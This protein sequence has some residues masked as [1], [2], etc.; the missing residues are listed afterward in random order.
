MPKQTESISTKQFLKELNGKVK[1]LG[2]INRAA[3]T[4]DVSATF[5]RLVLAGS[6]TP[7]KK[8]PAYLGYQQLPE[9]EI[10]YRYE[11]L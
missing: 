9:K 11:R 7:G 5:L 8:I 1:E 6:K 4:M 10:L 3:L 2:G